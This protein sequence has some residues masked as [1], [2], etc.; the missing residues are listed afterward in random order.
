MGSKYRLPS[1]EIPFTQLSLQLKYYKVYS[2]STYNVAPSTIKCRILLQK[3]CA[4]VFS[5][6]FPC[7]GF[8]IPF[9]L[10]AGRSLPKTPK[11]RP[12]FVRSNPH[13]SNCME[14]DDV[15]QLSARF[16]VQQF[17]SQLSYCSSECGLLLPHYQCFASALLLVRRRL[18]RQ[19]A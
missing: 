9:R 17:T 4:G 12:V 18:P 10:R 6:G 14:M 13:S 15:G 1:R 3:S 5:S 19:L 8:R 16:C 2:F 7:T 11:R